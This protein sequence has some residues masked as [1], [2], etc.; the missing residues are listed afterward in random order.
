[1]KDEVGKEGKEIE[2]AEN[3]QLLH[4]LHL[5]QFPRPLQLPRRQNIRQCSRKHRNIRWQQ[6]QCQGQH[7][8]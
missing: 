4:L 8:R 2:E 3:P 1:M 5:H 7:E 6:E